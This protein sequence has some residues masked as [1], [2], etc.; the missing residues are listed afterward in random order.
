MERKQPEQSAGKPDLQVED[1]CRPARK[2]VPRIAGRPGDF[3]GIVGARARRCWLLYQ[4]RPQGRYEPDQPRYIKRRKGRPIENCRQD[5][6]AKRSI[7]NHEATTIRSNAS[8]GGSIN[9]R[10]PR[11]PVRKL[12]RHARAGATKSPRPAAAPRPRRRRSRDSV[13]KFSDRRSRSMPWHRT[14]TAAEHRG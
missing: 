5:R 3:T 4:D 9:F 2:R 7:E 6:H 1:N 14:A 11:L 12:M 8:N 10:G 13:S